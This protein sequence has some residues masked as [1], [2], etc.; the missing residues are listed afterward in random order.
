M[1]NDREK[2]VTM[3]ESEVRALVRTTVSETLVSLGVEHSEPFEMQKDF[4]HLRSVRQ[5][6]EAMKKKTQMVLLGIFITSV[7]ATLT[8]GLK[9]YFKS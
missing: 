2:V 3:T 7:L 1:S 9:E 4:Q 8:V 5:S 6:S